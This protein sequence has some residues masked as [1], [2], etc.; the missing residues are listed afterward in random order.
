MKNIL[1]ALK[2]EVKMNLDIMDDLSEHKQKMVMDKLQLIGRISAGFI[3]DE[4]K[5]KKCN[6]LIELMY[7]WSIDNPY[8]VKHVLM[9]IGG[10]VELRSSGQGRSG[11]WIV[12]CKDGELYLDNE[13]FDGSIPNLLNF[14]EA[15]LLIHHV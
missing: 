8:N 7:E 14:I 9:F 10:T 13:K 11:K 4:E 5:A 2:T 1:D 6:Q 12:D 15:E 3:T